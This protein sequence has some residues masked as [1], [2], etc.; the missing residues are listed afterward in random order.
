MKKIN[1]VLLLSFFAV[2]VFL[3]SKV[4]SPIDPGILGNSQKAATY[5]AVTA[6]APINPVSFWQFSGANPAAQKTPTTGTQQFSGTENPTWTTGTGGKVGNFIDLS[7]SGNTAGNLTPSANGWAVEFLFKPSRTFEAGT[8]FSF[9]SNFKLEFQTPVGGNPNGSIARWKLVLNGTDYYID[10]DGAGRKSLG[11]IANGN[12]HHF[13]VQY[14]PASSQKVQFYID[15]QLPAGYSFTNTVSTSGSVKF[16]GM[17]SAEYTQCNCSLDQIALYDRALPPNLVL[18]HYNNV[19]SGSAYSTTTTITNVP[20][21]DSVAGVYNPLDFMAGT[22]LS[23]STGQTPGVTVSVIDQ[24]ES[25][26]LPRFKA[27]DTLIPN[28]GNWLAYD[29]L[30]NLASSSIS[31]A[32]IGNNA[33]N[34]AKSKEINK[35]LAT[36]WNYHIQVTNNTGSSNGFSA[37]DQ[38]LANDMLYIAPASNFIPIAAT[39]FRAQLYTS[40]CGRACISSKNLPSTHYLQ[41][42]SGQ[43][44]NPD[45]NVTTDKIWRPVSNYL[46]SYAPDGEAAKSHIQTVLNAIP[47]RVTQ[48]PSRAIDLINDNGEVFPP[49]TAGAVENVVNNDPMVSAAKNASGLDAYTYIARQFYT[50][51]RAYVDKLKSIPAV[52]N[53]TFTEYAIEGEHIF[54]YKWAEA[55]KVNDPINGIYYST[56]DFYIRYPWNWKYWSS[57]WHGWQW[58]VNSRVGEIA[59]GDTLFSPFISAG[60]DAVE[61][62][63]V[64]PAQMLGF[65][66]T[67]AVAGAEMFY[68]AAFNIDP[69]LSNNLYPENYVWQASTPGYVQGVTSYYEDILRNG[70][71]MRGDSTRLMYPPDTNPGFRFY[72]GNPGHLVV[73]RKQNSV[74][75]FVITGMENPWSNYQGNV[76]EES[77]ADIMFGGDTYPAIS[78]VSPVPTENLKFK[79]RRQGSTYIYDKTGATPVFYQLDTWH[80][81]SHPWHWSKDFSFESEVFD[82]N[83]GTISRTTTTPAGTQAGDYTNFTTYINPSSGSTT[84]KFEPRNATGTTAKTY[85]LWYFAK[86]STGTSTASVKVDSGTAQTISASSATFGWCN[87]NQGG[88]P[89]VFSGITPNTA[90]TFTFTGTSANFQLDKFILTENASLNLGSCGGTTPGDTTAPTVS[91]T[92]PTNGASI[93]TGPV[94]I[95]ATASDASGVASV[96]FKV[97]GVSKGIDTTTPYSVSWSLTGVS[98]GT[99][100]ITATATDNVGNTANSSVNVTV[101]TPDT[102]AP[103]TPTTLAVVRQSNSAVLSWGGSTDSGSGLAGYYVYRDGSATALNTNAITNL[104][105][106]DT[107]SANSSH[108]YIVKA[109]DNSGNFSSA[110]NQVSI[111]IDTAGPATTVTSPTASSTVNGTVN[112]SANVTDATGINH[113]EFYRG[114]T[115]ICTATATGQTSGTFSC[116]WNTTV[117]ANGSYQISAKAYDKVTIPGAN[118]TTTTAFTVTV[119]NV[120]VPPADTT[121]PTVS[122]TSPAGGATITG[123]TTVTANA[124][125]NT[126]VT[127]VQ[128]FTDSSTTAFATDSASPY[129]VTLNTAT[130]TNGTH[131]IKA[132]A[133]DAA[134]NN[135]TS[136]VVSVTVSNVTGQPD[137]VIT[138][139]VWSPANPAIGSNVSF[140]A[141]VKNQGTAGTPAGTVVGVMFTM[142]GVTLGCADGQTSSIAPGQTVSL[143]MGTG[144]AYCSNQSA[145]TGISTTWKATTGA[146]TIVAIVDDINIFVESNEANNTTTE[147]ITIGTDSSAPTVS[148]SS[149]ANGVVLTGGTTTTITAN[150]TDSSGIQNV[151]IYID[152]TQY[153]STLTTAPYSVSWNT[154]G[155]NAGS[156]AVTAIATDNAGNSSTSTAVSVSISTPSTDTIAP[157]VT[158]TCPN[159]SCNVNNSSTVTFTAN[160]IDNVAVTK[161]EFYHKSSLKCTLTSP[162]TPPS[163]YTCGIKIGG[164]NLNWLAQTISVK[165]YDAVGNVTTKSISAY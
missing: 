73:A 63:N 5:P 69:T 78:G 102:V 77:V 91:I 134:G 157:T 21:A 40:A 81:S 64:R 160:A 119:N 61:R 101:S 96:E 16:S 75:R 121:A 108:T 85:Y 135:T 163:T 116:P 113:I 107:P 74:N 45:G 93:T 15:G 56:P 123:S 71:L 38:A 153:G 156:H 126:G 86:S 65:S 149:P 129:S 53:T 44:L 158:F 9:G 138:D 83:T 132:K 41:N 20:T 117:I 125:D 147:T 92:A 79:V 47:N 32:S 84:Y 136:S 22:N 72:S 103:T 37:A 68:P 30:S 118:S 58:L 18:E 164:W 89:I 87:K 131:T 70:K 95:S 8:I 54:E 17:S 90:H 1:K 152:G 133:F 150:A 31:G 62:N 51:E 162:T 50:N 2:A 99:H 111:N 159:N 120:S 11:Y 97:D 109:K 104:G 130:L 13:V 165:A 98:N 34:H 161:V 144:T 110:S 128:F 60:W 124:S 94:A 57:A 112:M 100:Q 155:F 33:T 151:K 122:V 127:T 137:V 23:S 25:Y 82:S 43:F 106:T 7:G 46:S 114:T 12:W 88:T 142:D 139:I 19:N 29:Y 66:K 27:G 59:A 35:Q 42:S 36:K 140:T 48:N 80:E 14:D 26:P 3:F 143:S 76:P 115:L 4:I 154:T 55:R 145:D 10:L 52:A 141:S 67:L 39:S 148:I 24:L 28:I 6:S 49:Y 146:H 105:Y